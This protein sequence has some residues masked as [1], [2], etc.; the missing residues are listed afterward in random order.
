MLR[1][2]SR[3]IQR[4]SD[5]PLWVWLVNTGIEALI[6][7]A[8]LVL[9]TESPFMGPYRALACPGD[10][11]LLHLHHPLDL[12]PSAGPLLLDRP[13][14]GARLRRRD[15]LHARRLPGRP[16]FRGPG[17]SAPG[18]CHDRHPL[19][20][21]RHDR[22]VARRPVP[23]APRGRPARGRDP[24]SVRAT[25]A[26]DRPARTGGAGAARLGASLP[27]AHGRD[28]R[29]HRGCRPAGNHH[30]L[31]PGRPGDSSATRNRTCAVS[32]SRS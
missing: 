24:R 8:L 25:G 5:L 9:L 20:D 10:P 28:A 31:Q 21:L 3:A 2:V 29:R 7:T 11:R 1:L 26:R 13:G 12:A 22:G 14:L 16:G 6:P 32:R 19:P 18:V 23:P 17:L 27:A 30:A 15:R 4:R